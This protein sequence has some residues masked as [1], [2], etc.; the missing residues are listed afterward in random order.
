[1][2]VKEVLV[3]IS[4]QILRGHF[5]A[6]VVRDIGCMMMDEAVEVSCY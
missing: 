2:N 4:V 3:T 1:M 5:S 6:I